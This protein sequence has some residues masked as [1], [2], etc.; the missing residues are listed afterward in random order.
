MSHIFRY[1]LVMK[2]M[3]T[4]SCKLQ[5]TVEQIVKLNDLLKAFVNVCVYVNRTVEER[6]L[7]NS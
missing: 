5:V 7:T 4:V 2:Q 6:W 3:L 1:N